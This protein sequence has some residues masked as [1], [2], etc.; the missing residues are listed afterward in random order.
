ME[1]NENKALTAEEDAARFIALYEERERAQAKQV[2]F[3]KI[4]GTVIIALIIFGAWRIFM[5][6]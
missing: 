2:M 3:W 6:H 1:N 5:F 4:F